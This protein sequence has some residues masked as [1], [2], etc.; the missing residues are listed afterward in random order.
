[1]MKCMK[2]LFACI[3]AVLLTACVEDATNKDFVPV[4]RVKIGGIGE[5]RVCNMGDSLVIYPELKHSVVNSG[6]DEYNYLWYLSTKQSM[7]AADTLSEE[8]DLKVIVKT[9]PGEYHLT[10]KVTHKVTGVFNDAV[11]N[12][13]VDGAFSRGILVLAE[14]DGY[15]QLNFL[16]EQGNFV[17]GVY[18]GV[19]MEKLG[20]DPVGVFYVNP[21]Q[22]AP[23]LKEIYVLCKDERGGACMNPDNMKKRTDIRNAFFISLPDE[24][25]ESALYFKPK[26]AVMA[27]YLVINGKVYNRSFNMKEIRFK[28]ELVTANKGY[29][30]SAWHFTNPGT[31][32]FW[33]EQN[34]RFLAH[35]TPNKGT[36]LSFLP[37]D[38]SFDP[39]DIGLDLVCGGFGKVGR[40]NYIFG[41]FKEPGEGARPHYVLKMNL[42][43]TELK[44]GL[45]SRTEVDDSRHLL[46]ASCYEIP[47]YDYFNY[48]IFYAYGSQICVYNADNNVTEVLYD[49]GKEFP[50]RDIIVDCIDI[51]SKTD[52]RVG[53]RDRQ[54]EGKRGGYALLKLTEL[55]GLR[56]D[57]TVAPIMEFGF[58][59]KVVDFE[60]KL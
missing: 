11:C 32:Y 2:I 10:Y 48:L 45:A 28:S 53:I 57:H 39:N 16:P 17:T 46:S 40:P 27:D 22:N 47:H 49:F 41:L 1:M 15:A 13:R 51:S 58:C 30:V 60:T 34:R 21:S 56:V 59:D 9:L 38:E 42:E 20:K 7:G 19:N 25:I 26:T 14:N 4:D 54:L 3:W 5:N 23:A 50:E 43:I 44:I 55:G 8:K 37:V 24:I 35:N 12:L 29:K 52:L 33:D 6:D 36:L 31:A 18:E